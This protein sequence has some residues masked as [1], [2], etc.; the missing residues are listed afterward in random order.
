MFSHSITCFRESSATRDY[1]SAE[2]QTNFDQNSS[3]EGSIED[4]Y[5]KADNSDEISLENY[6]QNSHE[7]YQE[8]IYE[9][10]NLHDTSQEQDGFSEELADNLSYEL[11]TETLNETL[12]GLNEYIYKDSSYETSAEIVD[13]TLHENQKT[14]EEEKRLMNE[15]SETLSD[16]FDHEIA[17]I[18]NKVYIN[19]DEIVL[20]SEENDQIE[21]LPE[22]DLDKEKKISSGIF[23]ETP[24]N[25]AEEREDDSVDK[26]ASFYG[27][28]NQ[29]NIS[30]ESKLNN[31][32]NIE[33]GALEIK[34]DNQG[35]VD[36]K[37]LIAEVP[38]DGLE[39]LP[40]DGTLTESLSVLDQFLQEHKEAMELG[41][42]HNE[43]FDVNHQS[44]GTNYS[45]HEMA[46]STTS[47]G[48]EE[49][50]VDDGQS[51][52]SKDFSGEPLTTATKD[53]EQSAE[54]LSTLTS[55]IYIYI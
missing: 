43:D 11:L 41:S 52:A 35:P 26:I 7:L 9:P 5:D 19:E 13:Q 29:D 36:Q 40:V 8:T 4:Q 1:G 45:V 34:N 24:Y 10:T 21:V 27:S 37:Q 22:L 18:Y 2:Y 3:S 25:Y 15:P 47:V 6:D 17:E 51:D 31:E 55:G 33:T 16:N 39:S 32:E 23:Q 42:E 50:I 30:G 12:P 38:Q 49:E 44:N 46:K 53:L 28:Q 20:E 54:K 14:G 48:A